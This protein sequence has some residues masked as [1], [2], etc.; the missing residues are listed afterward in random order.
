VLSRSVK[1][2]GLG[3]NGREF[4][5]LILRTRFLFLVKKLMRGHMTG[6]SV[7]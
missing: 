7:R 2:L 1:Y 6:E 3:A 4:W 5:H